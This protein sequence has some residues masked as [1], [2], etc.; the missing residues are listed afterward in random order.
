MDGSKCSTRGPRGPKKTR[1]EL[2]NCRMP[3]DGNVITLGF[4]S[5]C[6]CT[7]IPVPK[8]YDSRR[9]STVMKKSKIG[10]YP[11]RNL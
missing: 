10:S 6:L 3:I 9:E 5:L 2:Y 4:N 11:M 1:Q 7:K 8:N